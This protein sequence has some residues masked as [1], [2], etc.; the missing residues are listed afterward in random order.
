MDNPYIITQLLSLYERTSNLI[1]AG[2]QATARHVRILKAL[3]VSKKE[4]ITV[5]SNI[6][7][8]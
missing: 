1:I 6:S 7:I 2:N 4:T 5:I 3:L 8:M